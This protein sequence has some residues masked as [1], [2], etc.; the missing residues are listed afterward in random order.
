[1]YTEEQ[2]KTMM[3]ELRSYIRFFGYTG[4]NEEEDGTA[5]TE[6]F[7][8]ESEELKTVPDKEDSLSEVNGYKKVNEAS[9]AA[10]GQP[11]DDYPSYPLY[12][13]AHASHVEPDPS[14]SITEKLTFKSY[15]K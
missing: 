14:I 9:L 2:M 7:D 6:F 5:N 8:F 11:K 12:Q 13:L 4:Q 3:K 15:D 1:M 10:C